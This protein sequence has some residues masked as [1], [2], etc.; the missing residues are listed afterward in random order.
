[1]QDIQPKNEKHKD[2]EEIFNRNRRLF[3]TVAGTGVVA[4]ILGKIFG[5]SINLFSRDHV[6]S[7]EE[8]KNFRVVN[9]EKEM[10]LYDRSGD[11]IIIIEKEGLVD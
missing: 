6:L 10:R 9:T 3:L 2:K 8:F 11:E 4:F 7:E 5:P 1:M